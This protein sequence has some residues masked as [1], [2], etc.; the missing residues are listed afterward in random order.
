MADKARPLVAGDSLPSA[1]WKTI[2]GETFST[3]S[4]AAD[5]WR[6]LVVYR[7]KHCGMCKRYL[8]E[9]NGLLE[10]F[11]DAGTDVFAVSADS[12]SAAQAWVK[13]LGLR[14]PLG[15]GLTTDQMRDLGLYVS[16]VDD[17]V[18]HEFAEPAVFVVREDGRLHFACVGNA[19]YGRPPLSDVLDGLEKARKDGLEPH[20]TA[21][22]T[23]EAN[24]RS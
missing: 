6:L 19:P 22:P 1:K 3:R 16:P 8:I 23:P 14:F 17:D 10:S 11:Q 4:H 12:E 15:F 13:E 7:G 21:W 9:L 24:R 18:D 2:Q 5:R 20:G